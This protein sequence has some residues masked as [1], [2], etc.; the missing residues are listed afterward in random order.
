M[1]GEA[2]DRVI[3]YEDHYT[4]GRPE[5]EIIRLLREGLASGKRVRQIDEFAA[6]RD[7]GRDSAPLSP[8]GRT[9]ACPGR[10]HRRNCPVRP[11]VFRSITAE[12]VLPVE[13]EKPQTAQTAESLESAEMADALLSRAPAIAKVEPITQCP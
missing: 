7:G 12:P 6:P 8:A 3:L 2:F 11:P 9:D 5:G 10:C 1:L 4:R 13:V